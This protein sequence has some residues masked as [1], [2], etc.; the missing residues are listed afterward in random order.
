MSDPRDPRTKGRVEA[1]HRAIQAVNRAATNSYCSLPVRNQREL[2]D[3]LAAVMRVH[4]MATPLSDGIALALAFAATARGLVLINA[5]HSGAS[6]IVVTDGA[7]S[8]EPGI[9]GAEIAQAFADIARQCDRKLLLQILDCIKEEQLLALQI[10]ADETPCE[11]PDC[12]FLRAQLTT[13]GS[14]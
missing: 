11:C 4:G 14:N 3:D 7:I 10:A 5:L 9:T 12:L 13:T 1:A 2:V 6:L 8:A